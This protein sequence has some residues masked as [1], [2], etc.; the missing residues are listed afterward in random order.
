MKIAVFHKTT[1]YEPNTSK[2]KKNSRSPCLPVPLS[3]APYKKR[4]YAHTHIRTY[5][6]NTIFLKA[7]FFPTSSRQM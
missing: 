6:T 1:S 3:P 2:N 4:T 5:L 7:L